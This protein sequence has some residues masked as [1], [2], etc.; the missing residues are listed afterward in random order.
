MKRVL[1][2]TAAAVI[3]LLFVSCAGT[4]PVPK[5]AKFLNDNEINLL[6]SDKT[7][8]GLTSGSGKPY[9]I[10]FNS[11]N[12]FKGTANSKAISG[13]WFIKDGSK[14][15]TL[16]SKNYC[17]KHYKLEGKYYTYNEEKNSVVPF[18]IR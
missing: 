7:A 13:T 1:V 9:E 3:S 11:N 2:G 18:D 16:N 5:N 14:C 10:K 17:S 12:T 4:N 15:V 6:F 8:S